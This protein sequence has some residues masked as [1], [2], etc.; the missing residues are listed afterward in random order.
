MQHPAGRTFEGK[1]RSLSAMMEKPPAK[2]ALATLDNPP[3][4]ADIRSA[5][6]ISKKSPVHV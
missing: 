3:S 1:Q 4:R 2:R 6:R 5:R